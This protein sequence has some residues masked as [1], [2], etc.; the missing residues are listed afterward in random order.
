MRHDGCA[1]G[2]ERGAAVG[3]QLL[4]IARHVKCSQRGV[5]C[6]EAVQRVGLIDF[7][8]IPN[9]MLVHSWATDE[10]PRTTRAETPSLSHSKVTQGLCP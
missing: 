1:C 3:A 8:R 6:S 2:S 9:L 5:T 10:G 4:A 7:I